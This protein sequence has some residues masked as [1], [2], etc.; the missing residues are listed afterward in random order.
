M[1]LNKLINKYYQRVRIFIYRRLSTAVNIKGA[2]DFYQPTVL[3]GAGIIVFGTNVRFG[4]NP[5][6]GFYN[7]TGYVEARNIGAKV[8]FGANIIINN[9]VNIICDKT[10]IYIG[11]DVL[12]GC[13]VEILDSDFHEINPARRN[14]GNHICLPV[15][16]ERNVFIGNG[17]SILKGVTIGE[18]SVIANKSVVTKSFPANVIIGGNPAK[19]IKEI[20]HE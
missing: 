2:A 12:I 9:A 18:N 13:N 15:K 5:S 6:P 8:I 7:T 14:E 10:E 11:D 3:N 1:L 19:I 16:I 20:G 17:V 4:Y